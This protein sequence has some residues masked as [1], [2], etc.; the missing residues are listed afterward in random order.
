M[1]KLFI[2]I[3]SVATIATFQSCSSVS[4][5]PQGASGSFS[6]EQDNADLIAYKKEQAG[7]GELFRSLMETFNE[8][9]EIFGDYVGGD[10]CYVSQSNSDL[11]DFFASNEGSDA[12]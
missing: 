8:V 4:G 1:K 2:L 5:R 12:Y 11:R 3:F 7:F 10:E 6:E 9:C